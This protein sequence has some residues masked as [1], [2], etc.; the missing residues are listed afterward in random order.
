MGRRGSGPVSI[1]DEQS[2][3]VAT[4]RDQFD[5]SGAASP[6]P[7]PRMPARCRQACALSLHSWL[8]TAT[9]WLRLGYRR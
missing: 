3:V 9:D 7:L 1:T 5:L 2:L 8:N 4:V 6:S